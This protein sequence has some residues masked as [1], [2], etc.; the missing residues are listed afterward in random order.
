[1]VGAEW[2]I[3]QKMNDDDLETM[4]IKKKTLASNTVGL[5]LWP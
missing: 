5:N 4:K 2:K 3:I 1:M